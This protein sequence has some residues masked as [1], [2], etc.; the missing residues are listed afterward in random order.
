MKVVSIDDSEGM[1]LCHDITE[2]VPGSFKGRA[3]K[4][5]H[6]VKKEDIPKLLKLGKE[7]LYVWEINNGFLHEDDAAMRLAKAAGGK[8]ITMKGPAEGKVEL[9]A[10]YSGLLKIN[11]SLLDMIN[12]IDQVVLATIHTN[13][14][15]PAGRN[16]AGC[17]VV[18]LVIETAKI[19]K[20][21][22]LCCEYKP[23]IEVKP[24]KSHKVG[25][26]TTG[27]EVFHGRIEDQF[28][29]VIKKKF[30]DLG[31]EV[32]R[33]IFVPD[34]MDMIIEAIRTLLDDGVDLITATGGMSVDPDDLTP[35]GIRAAGGRV[36]IY[37]TPVL[38]GSMFMLA[39]IGNIPVLGLPGCV[40]Y[41]KSTIFDLVVPRILAGED[42]QKKDILRLAHGGMCSGC[43]VC[44]FP[45][46]SFG[47][48]S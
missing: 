4:K 8:G 5:G 43:Q 2:I 36:V 39:Y 1:V 33:Q 47:K 15:V 37:G 34:D 19:E 24:L 42:V 21:E 26:V 10:G 13:Q 44:S 3:F 31:S 38:P 16:V 18:P 22:Q 11:V 32:V 30:S 48:G 46:C 27:S 25:I 6:V 28:G 14:L 20:A 17:R 12:D 41:N 35:A 7:H 23:L 40:M 45:N 29:P 9:I